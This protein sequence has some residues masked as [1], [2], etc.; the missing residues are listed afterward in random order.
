MECKPTGLKF[1]VRSPTR[2]IDAPAKAF[3]S[4]RFRQ[5]RR[6][7]ISGKSPNAPARPRWR[8]RLRRA[9]RGAMRPS[10]DPAA[11]AS[12]QGKQEPRVYPVSLTSR[13]DGAGPPASVSRTLAEWRKH[14]QRK[15]AGGPGFE[16]RLTESESA[17]LPLNYPPSM[18]RRAPLGQCCN[19][20]GRGLRQECFAGVFAGATRGNRRPALT[21]R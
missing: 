5:L 12:S 15:V 10:A 18:A 20:E 3:Q 1:A 17:V 13:R 6:V 11:A 8:I 9:E 21:G 2:G 4:Q 16:P 14:W 7:G 19:I